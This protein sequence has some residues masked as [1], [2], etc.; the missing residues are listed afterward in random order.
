MKPSILLIC[1][2]TANTHVSAQY[3]LSGSVVGNGGS[4][5]ANEK[6][7]SHGTIGQSVIWSV[8]NKENIC[9]TGLWYLCNGGLQPVFVKEN[10]IPKEFR[11]KG[12]YPNPFNSSTTITFELPE[13]SH[14]KLKIF[15]A[16][17][18]IVT[19]LVDAKLKEGLQ[20]V[21]W[22]P[23]GLS[24]GVY[25]YSIEVKTMLLKG[26]MLLLKW[27]I[28]NISMYINLSIHFFSKYPRPHTH[29]LKYVWAQVN[30]YRKEPPSLRREYPL[31]W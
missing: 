18:Q 9:E 17:G 6:Y 13:Q 26:K 31:L 7:N 21:I 16:S 27:L 8:N 15:S 3:I 30:I 5:F 28:Y 24:G 11:L 14:V 23:E 4:F 22:D 1:L 12:N 19:T 25:L 10:I 20:T 2:M 29:F